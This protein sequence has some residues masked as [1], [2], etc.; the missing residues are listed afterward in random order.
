[1]VALSRGLCTRGDLSLGNKKHGVN[2]TLINTFTV[3]LPDLTELDLPCAIF[4]LP[5]IDLSA[6]NI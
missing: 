1:M 2:Y 4:G 3:S 5:M 6:A